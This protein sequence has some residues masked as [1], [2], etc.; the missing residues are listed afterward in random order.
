[1]CDSKCNLLGEV[2]VEVHVEDSWLHIGQSADWA[3][4]GDGRALTSQGERSESRL[5]IL[6]VVVDV[7]LLLGGLL[8]LGPLLLWLLLG[9]LLSSLGD[10]GLDLLEL[11]G[12]GL[13]SSGGD[14]GLVEQL[15]LSG[16][17]LLL[18]LLELLLL[19]LLSLVLL[20]LLSLDGQ[21]FLGELLEL[22]HSLQV[23][24]DLGD[25]SLD[26]LH[27][28]LSVLL[29]EGLVQQLLLSL[30]DLHLDLSELLV[31]EL[32]D[33]HGGVLSQQLLLSLGNQ[34]LQL[35]ELHVQLLW[36]LLEQLL[37]LD[38]QL[39]LELGEELLELLDLSELDGLANELDQLLL[40]LD[41][42]ELL[43][44]ELLQLDQ[45]LLQLD[46]MVLHL[47]SVAG[48][49]QL[50]LSLGNEA[51]DLGQQLLLDEELSLELL[52][53]LELTLWQLLTGLDELLLHLLLELLDGHLALGGGLDLLDLLLAELHAWG[54]AH[55]VHVHL[56]LHDVLL[57]L[58]GLG[59]LGGQD[60]SLG[61]DLADEVLDLL[62]LLVQVLLHLSLHL[63]HLGDHLESNLSLDWASQLLHM[64]SDHLGHFGDLL[65]LE[66]SQLLTVQ[67]VLNT[68]ELLFLLSVKLLVLLQVL[69]WVSSGAS[70]SDLLWQLGT[71][72][73]GHGD[74][75][76]SLL[77]S[78]LLEDGI[79]TLL[80]LLEGLG[81]WSGGQSDLDGESSLDVLL[82][83]LSV[84]GNW[85]P[86]E[87]GD[88][89]QLLLQLLDGLA[90]LWVLLSLGLLG[91]LDGLLVELLTEL[92]LKSQ[93]QL[94]DLLLLALDLGQLL[95]GPQTLL[96]LLGNTVLV[97]LLVLVDHGLDLEGDLLLELEQW[98]H[99][100]DLDG[101][102]LG[103]D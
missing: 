21:Q 12:S 67:W 77:D 22:W 65:L 92:L 35:N 24:L 63:L 78:L 13:L 51:L 33:W 41:E 3:L 27:L 84:L 18:D 80:S 15:L 30:S 42:P 89:L 57:H 90:G 4:L 100:L 40:D 31:D 72:W 5:N 69:L 47:L 32:T 60:W 76:G 48:Q 85:S 6:E 49:Q 70:V 20:T 50:L 96:S 28:L 23:L 39:V 93:L 43:S 25:Q 101:N 54:D 75:D 68:D 26:L 79:L 87:H 10:L 2:T 7:L 71:D 9:Q 83:L 45:L 58:H 64:L 55:G 52:L 61:L 103:L 74:L 94:L 16:L 38:G 11:L 81:Q 95:D 62:E 98:L 88:L 56:Q 91:D 99:L 82:T 17:D 66:L 1:M 53:S 97:L 19:S 29:V 46:E 34:H 59:D 73:H 8:D 44:E 102:L 86:L 37:L 14:W 36:V